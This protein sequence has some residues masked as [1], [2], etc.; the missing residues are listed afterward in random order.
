MYFRGRSP[1][2]V[3]TTPGRERYWQRDI[4]AEAELEQPVECSVPGSS[5]VKLSLVLSFNTHSAES[6]CVEPTYPYHLVR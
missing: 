5:S 2:S 1:S 6:T 4:S 3:L